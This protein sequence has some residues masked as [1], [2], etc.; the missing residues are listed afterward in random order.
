MVVKSKSDE[1]L[2][3]RGS[4]YAGAVRLCGVFVRTVFTFHVTLAVNSVAIYGVTEI[5]KQRTIATFRGGLL[6]LHSAK[7]GTVTIVLTSRA[8]VMG[9]GGA[10]AIQLGRQFVLYNALG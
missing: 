3:P 6:C 1:R 8:P 2:N 7:A 5:T 10:N 4:Y 9:I